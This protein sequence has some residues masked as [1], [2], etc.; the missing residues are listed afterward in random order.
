MKKNLIVVASILIFAAI[1]FVLSNNK[2][3]TSIKFS[4]TTSRD[5]EILKIVQNDFETRI[6]FKV[7]A[8]KHKIFGF[9]IKSTSTYIQNSKGG[10]KLYVYKSDSIEMD[11]VYLDT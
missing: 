9:Q 6:D 1:L 2:K 8:V 11:K 3:N 10:E 4:T 7:N 5:V